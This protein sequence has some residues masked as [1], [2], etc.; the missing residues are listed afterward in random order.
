M[1]LNLAGHR[2]VPGS[3]HGRLLAAGVA[4]L[5]LTLTLSSC[6]EPGA[7]E[8][9]FGYVV[10]GTVTT[11]NAN[12]VAGSAS[13]SRQ[14]FARALGGFSFAGPDG[15]AVAD[16]DFGEASV[17]PGD[18]L[19]VDYQINP[20]A[21]Y[22]D[23]AP[24]VCDDMVLAW[25]AGSGTFTEDD[26][27][28]GS[29]PLFEAAAAPGMA[30]IESIDCA[31][32]S[33]SAVVSF[34]SG[35]AIKDWQALFG[36][37]TV[38]PSH[39]VSAGSGGTEI[40][41]AVQERDDAAMAEI[42]TFW[43]TGF[44]LAPGVV[45]SEVFV[46]SGP[47]RLDSVGEDGSVT[48]KAN[49]LW[50][51]DPPRTGEI[52]VW[53]RDSDLDGLIDDGAVQVL[54]IR[55]GSAEVGD[56]PP[57]FQKTDAGSN[58]IEQLTLS[59]RG[60]LEP[61]AARRALSLCVPREKWSPMADSRL[62]LDNTLAYPFVAGTV[63]GRYQRSDAGSAE[64]EL[65]KAGVDGL[66]V[67]I[68][69]AAPDAQRA[70][71]VAEIAAAC[72]PAGITVEDVSTPDFDPR[73]LRADEVDAVLGGAGGVQVVGGALSEDARTAVL[74]GDAQGNLGGFNDTGFDE[75]VDQ[76]AVTTDRTDMLN[77]QRDAEAILWD[78]LPSLPLYPQT[79]TVLFGDGLS[80]GSVSA[81]AFGA[82]WNMDRWELLR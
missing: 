1:E 9:A 32:G 50:W 41:R 2:R 27:A 7:E 34:R 79:R 18:R 62:A 19:T 10:D 78:A 59:T 16:S 57:G 31:A 52:T 75:I 4:G 74:R 71:V 35:R 72:A 55:T 13:A 42:A 81:S 20:A 39:V 36:A 60:A 54:D 56:A 15:S 45:D 65:D 33:K 51:G 24:V 6:T 11:Y 77:L 64:A 14:A 40:V 8:K 48:L 12:T 46:S 29:K 28:G 67:R 22:S 26:G 82:G 76:L 47:Y 70:R 69:Y 49:D 38:M 21:T 25:A 37:T 44:T 73:A 66:T 3:P 58:G 63:D 53:P 30:D 17:L 80:A 61:L 43:N 23:G 68:G 5:A